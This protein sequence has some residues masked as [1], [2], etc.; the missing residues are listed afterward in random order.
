MGDVSHRRR[1][2]GAG[3]FLSLS[4][5]FSVPGPAEAGIIIPSSGVIYGPGLVDTADVDGEGDE[6]D[7]EEVDE[8]IEKGVDDTSESRGRSEHER[9]GELEKEEEDKWKRWGEAVV[10]FCES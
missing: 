10:V 9:R 8:D 1:L 3:A 7:S 2:S 5:L 4:F 6:G